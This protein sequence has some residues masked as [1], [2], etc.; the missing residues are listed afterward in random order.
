[1]GARR[2]LSI[3]SSRLHCGALPNFLYPRRSVPPPL[4]AIWTPLGLLIT[5][6]VLYF[7]ICRIV[8][9]N[10]AAR[11]PLDSAILT[12]EHGKR[13]FSK[14]DRRGKR[15]YLLSSHQRI[16]AAGEALNYVPHY[17]E[18]KSKVSR[19]LEENDRIP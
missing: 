18:W 6:M 1:M 16:M 13:D 4:K 11:A 3:C 14:W 8:F 12:F 5:L 19:A 17:Q 2:F 9:R 10:T 7:L 15:K